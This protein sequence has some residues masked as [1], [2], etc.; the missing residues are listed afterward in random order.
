MVLFKAIRNA[1][2]RALIL[3]ALAGG[4]TAS[5]G[6]SLAWAQNQEERQRLEVVAQGQPGFGRIILKFV[7]RLNLL[8]TR[9]PR[10]V[11]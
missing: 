8:H 7:D 1:F 2:C 3:S 4:I 11:G 10:A 6:A 9:S 5:S